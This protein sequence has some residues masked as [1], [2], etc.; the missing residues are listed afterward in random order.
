MN[1]PTTLIFDDSSNNY[2]LSD[3]KIEGECIDFY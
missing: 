1:L 2:D 3:S